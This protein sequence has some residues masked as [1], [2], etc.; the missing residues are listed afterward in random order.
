MKADGVVRS[1]NRTSVFVKKT[2]I[3]AAQSNQERTSEKNVG[4]VPDT[5]KT[6]MYI[7]LL[8]ASLLN[9]FVDRQELETIL[10]LHSLHAVGTA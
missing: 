5:K 9:L 6:I 7:F 4:K 2:E 1:S 10:V 8:S 3:T